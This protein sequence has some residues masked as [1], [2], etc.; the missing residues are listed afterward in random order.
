MKIKGKHVIVIL[1]QIFLSVLAIPGAFII[2]AVFDIK[3]NSKFISAADGSVGPGFYAYLQILGVILLI[4][5][6]SFPL[7]KLMKTYLIKSN[8][9]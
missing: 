1:I 3:M 8:N 9:H 4:I 5:W 2:M 6:F 7:F